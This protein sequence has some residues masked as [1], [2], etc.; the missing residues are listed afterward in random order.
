M[1]GRLDH[2][3]F[4]TS[5]WDYLKVQARKVHCVMIWNAVVNNWWW[6]EPSSVFTHKQVEKEEDT[7]IN[8]HCATTVWRPPS[9]FRWRVWEQSR[10]WKFNKKAEM[11]NRKSTPDGP[12]NKEYS[13][14]QNLW[15][16]NPK[17]FIRQIQKSSNLAFPESNWCWCLNSKWLIK[18][19]N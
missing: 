7:F 6:H 16:L 9:R 10:Q 3:R 17:F 13:P 2:L 1:N 18:S 15:T 19:A 4:F 8:I 5:E 12:T 14:P 11:S